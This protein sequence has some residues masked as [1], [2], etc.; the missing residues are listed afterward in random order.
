MNAT[1]RQPCSRAAVAMVCGSADWQAASTSRER[2]MVQFWQN[3]QPR[4]QPG[5]P[6]ESTAVP[7]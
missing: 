4:L 6:N 5:V 1:L 7:G 3:V 2:D